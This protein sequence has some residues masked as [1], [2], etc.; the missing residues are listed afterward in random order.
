MLIFG[1]AVLAQ[2]GGDC[3][4]RVLSAAVEETRGCG[5]GVNVT[6][7]EVPHLCVLWG[8]EGGLGG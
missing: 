4:E 6:L 2:H 8:G 1:G 7:V 3:S 5:T